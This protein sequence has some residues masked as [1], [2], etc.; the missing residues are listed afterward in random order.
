MT[1]PGRG[2]HLSTSGLKAPADSG[3]W[4]DFLTGIIPTNIADAFLKVNV[5]QIVFLAVVAGAAILKVGEKAAP[6]LKLNES[7]LELVQTALW[8]VIRLAPLG[9]LGLIGK[10]VAVYGWDLLQPL[11]TFTADI[12]LG[13]ALVLFGVY[14]LLLRF[15]GGLN[16]LNF[17]KGAWP[18]IQLA[19]VSRSSVGTLPVTRRVTERLGVPGEYASFAVPLGSRS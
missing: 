18:A 3:S 5:L 9:T 6:I 2:T 16:P 4:V 14:P 19:F 8:W 10:S 11:A 1:N 17:F 12:Y 13:C 15:V 7:L